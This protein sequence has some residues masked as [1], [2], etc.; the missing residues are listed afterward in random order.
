MFMKEGMMASFRIKHPYF[1]TLDNSQLLMDNLFT[2][3]TFG[4]V[5][6]FP[7]ALLSCYCHLGLS[8]G[9]IYLLH[10]AL[11]ILLYLI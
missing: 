7:R 10:T 6:T 1:H 2:C 11:H 5:A 8:P 4:H 3:V 9:N